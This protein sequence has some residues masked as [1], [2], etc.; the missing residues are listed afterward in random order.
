MLF[1]LMYT[2]VI[3]I[4]DN[5]LICTALTAAQNELNEA[6]SG[7]THTHTHTQT[8]TQSLKCSQLFNKII[9]L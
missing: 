9:L 3:K 5:A 7:L 4:I 1:L 6:R 8:N 2:F